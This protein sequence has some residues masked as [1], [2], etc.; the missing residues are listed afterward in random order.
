MQKELQTIITQCI[1]VDDVDSAI[2]Q[3]E[4]ESFNI[5]PGEMVLVVEKQEK[6]RVLTRKKWGFIPEWSKDH[7]I[8]N[9][10]INARAETVFQKPSFKE[11]IKRK[12]CL[13]IGS[14]YYEWAGTGEKREPIYI[15]EPKSHFITFGG[16]Y[17]EWISPEGIPMN[18]CLIITTKSNDQI[19]HIYKRMPVIISIENQGQWLSGDTPREII[20][21]L[22]SP[23]KGTMAY[24]KVGNNV[25]DISRKDKSLIIPMK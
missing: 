12:R 13:I 7:R 10:L 4:L 16:I 5:T 3:E 22:L 21:E 11:A 15:Y 8:G 24:H 2:K 14:G 23:Y 17:S 25:N 18:T 20:E 6:R 19:S 1:E 9:K